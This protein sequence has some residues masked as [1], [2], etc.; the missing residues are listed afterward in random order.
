[1][2]GDWDRRLTIGECE[3]GFGIGIWDSDLDFGIVDLDGGIE[4]GDWNQGLRI[5]D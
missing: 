2:I 5:G 4:T 3:L 1:M